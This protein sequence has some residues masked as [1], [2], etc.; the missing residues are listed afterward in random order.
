M[1]SKYAWAQGFYRYIFYIVNTG[2]NSVRIFF[3]DLQVFSG[4]GKPGNLTLFLT[5]YRNTGMK[6]YTVVNPKSLKSIT[7]HYFCLKRTGSFYL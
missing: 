6:Q 2:M 1:Y 5:V 3:C 7:D 4:T